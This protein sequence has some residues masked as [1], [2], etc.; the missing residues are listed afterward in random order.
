MAAPNSTE[1]GATAST[2]STNPYYKKKRKY[3]K[4]RKYRKKAYKKGKR[5]YSKKRRY[6]RKYRKKRYT[7]KRHKSKAVLSGGPRPYIAPRRPAVVRFGRK[8]RK[9]NIV[10]DTAGRRLYYVLSKGKAYSYPIAVGKPGFSWSGTK[11]IT[12]KK[13]WPDW[14]P[15][16]EMRK[17]KPNLPKL[18]TGGIYN[19]LGAKALYLGSSLYRIHGTNNLKSIGTASSSGCFRMSNSHVA[20]LSKMAGVGTTVHVK[21]RLSKKA[22]GYSKKKRRKYSK[23]RYRKGRRG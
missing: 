13:N 2:K 12:G 10:I 7:K 23:R 3:S 15:P 6:G 22:K 9:G 19:P 11:R 8:Y 17:R 20:H 14:R 21:R 18:M 16:A 1:N 5:R 4:K